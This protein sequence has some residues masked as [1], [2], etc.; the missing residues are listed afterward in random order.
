[1][2]LLQPSQI[3]EVLKESGLRKEP[4]DKSDLKQLLEEANLT[5]EDCL[6][7]VAS[8]MRSGANENT[9]L[10]ATKMALEL[11]GLLNK[12]TVKNAPVFIINVNGENIGLNPILVPR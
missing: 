5:P 4:G 8:L 6:D 2:P 9:R 7:Q 11:N 1:M 10:S 3:H 12:D